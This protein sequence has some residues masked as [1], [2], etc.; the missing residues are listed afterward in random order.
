MM[1]VSAVRD[2]WGLLNMAQRRSAIALLIMM[3]LAMLLETAFTGLVMPTLGLI[4]QT[5]VAR[6]YPQ[7]QSILG[8][9]GGSTEPRTVVFAMALLAAVSAA[10]LAFVASL[11]LYQAKFAFGLQ[12]NLAERLFRGYLYQPWTFHLSRN[13]AQ[14]IRNATTEV[15]LFT[16]LVISLCLVLTE[17]FV[18]LGIAFLLIIVEPVGALVV[19]SCLTIAALI[20]W[21]MTRRHLFNWGKARQH[22][23]GNRIQHLQQGLGG[24]KEVKLSGHEAEFLA[25]FSWH[26]HMSAAAQQRL[27][28]VQQ[29]P[30][31]WLEFLATV[32]LALLVLVLVGSGKPL[33]QLLPTI[34]MFAVAAFRLMPSISRLITS[35]QVLRYNLP[36]LTMLTEEMKTVE[37]GE[38]SPQKRNKM[39]FQ[40]E[41]QLE[42]VTFKY[43]GAEQD[44]VHNVSLRI[45]VG[46]T[47]GF[48]GS[49]GAGKSTL[50]DLILGLLTPSSGQILVDGVPII[51]RVRA[52]QNKIG[53]VPQSIFLTDDT[54][55]RNIA[56]GVADNYIDDESVARAIRAA[57]LEEF[58]AGLENGTETRVGERGVRLSG[59]QRQRIGIA[60][61]LYHNPPV[62]VLDE[63][64]SSLDTT[65][66]QG[67]MGAVSALHGEKTIIIIAHRLSTV[68]VCDEIFCLEKGSIVAIGKY[69]E[70]LGSARDSST[71]YRPIDGGE[72]A[73][74]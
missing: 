5:D 15:G 26:N 21:Q 69:E 4:T 55:R 28:A 37:S 30:R 33:E 45:P 57:Q 56:F 49:S 70:I 74:R 35:T 24:A 63:A 42:N 47:V 6:S 8:K 48:I 34:G 29:L 64:T 7:L 53:Y 51:N 11:A 38:V 43:D 71:G 73:R 19:T 46:T 67:V 14:L 27:Q 61:A 31:L 18:A 25:R 40:S 62:I 50:V 12:A 44:A 32:G 41:I 58:V 54:I 60:R 9:F 36:V 16:S 59:G 13:S 23:E 22:H 17:G 1:A 72:H 39:Q 10:K 20:F 52:W 65:N 3:L 2:L 68:E 66:E